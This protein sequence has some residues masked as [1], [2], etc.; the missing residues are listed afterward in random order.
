[1]GIGISPSEIATLLK[2][3]SHDSHIKWMYTQGV[4][5]HAAPQVL[6]VHDDRCCQCLCL[7]LLHPPAPGD[8]AKQMIWA[9][10]L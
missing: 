3:C 2:A 9:F 6:G 5:E 1:M 10:I 7:S 4:E 8:A